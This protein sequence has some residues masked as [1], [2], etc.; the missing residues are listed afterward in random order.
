[1]RSTRSDPTATVYSR[2]RVFGVLILAVTAQINGSRGSAL[3]K[4]LTGDENPPN[5]LLTAT[6]LLDSGRPATPAQGL[7]SKGATRRLSKGESMEGVLTTD[8]DTENHAHGDARRGTPCRPQRGIPSAS[9]DPTQPACID[10]IQERLRRLLDSG[11]SSGASARLL[12]VK[13]FSFCDNGAPGSL[14]ALRIHQSGRISSSR[15]GYEGLEE[16]VQGLLLY[17]HGETVQGARNELHDWRRRSELRGSRGR[18]EGVR[19]RD[20]C[21]QGPTDQ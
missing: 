19:P 14:N 21:S 13:A 10:T 17:S 20:A 5:S 18:E 1:L 6:P 15:K 11:R 12:T 9:S 7:N 4:T 3:L 2:E 8:G 16:P